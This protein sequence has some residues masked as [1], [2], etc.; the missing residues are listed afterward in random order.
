MSDTDVEELQDDIL[1]RLDA[2]EQKVSWTTGTVGANP[3]GIVVAY[4][5]KYVRLGS[6]EG[7]RNIALD[8]ARAI[9]W[10]ALWAGLNM[11]VESTGERLVFDVFGR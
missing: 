9:H 1:G 3:F 4:T 6:A 5:S 8:D 2:G 10:S 7:G 11:R